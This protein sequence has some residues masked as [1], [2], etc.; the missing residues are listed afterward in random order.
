M[1]G[2]TGLVAL[3]VGTFLPW[4]TSGS[5]HRNVYRAGN[6]LR[7]VL[8]VRGV[9]AV[10]LDVLPFVGLWCAAVA[11]AY[12]LGYRRV[13]CAGGLLVAAAALS[14]AIGALVTGADGFVK[15]APAGPIVTILGALFVAAAATV[16]LLPERAGPSLQEQS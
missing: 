1:L 14:G 7:G 3:V 8:G 5:S 10:G 6:A 16:L 9:A 2:A 4:L 13:A 11:I 15:A 12:A